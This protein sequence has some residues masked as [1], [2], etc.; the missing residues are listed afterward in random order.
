M[1]F[2]QSRISKLIIKEGVHLKAKVMP[3]G[4][5]N[6]SG[7]RFLTNGFVATLAK[8]KEHRLRS[9]TDIPHDSNWAQQIAEVR[10]IIRQASAPEYILRHR[11]LMREQRLLFWGHGIFNTAWAEYSVSRLTTTP[12]GPRPG[13]VRFNEIPDEYR[14]IYRPLTR[15]QRML[16]WEQG[17]FNTAWANIL[18]VRITGRP[19]HEDM[20]LDYFANSFFVLC[21]GGGWQQVVRCAT[22]TVGANNGG[23]VFYGCS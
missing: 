15:A 10:R 16:F 11:S 12:A 14:I 19:E 5:L 17:I 13:T 18:V 6:S 21:G 7:A 3:I 2:V 23:N 4:K 1:Q 22:G 8:K 9:A 20:P